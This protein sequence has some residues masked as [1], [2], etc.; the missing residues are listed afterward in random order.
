MSLWK[1]DDADDN[2][3]EMFLKLQGSRYCKPFD[4]GND[5]PILVR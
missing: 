2:V 3:R 5:D 4:A 1:V